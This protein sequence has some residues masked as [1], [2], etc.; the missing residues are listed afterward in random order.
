MLILT[1][2]VKLLDSSLT[3]YRCECAVFAVRTATLARFQWSGPT[4]VTG[5]NWSVEEA[6]CD[7]AVHIDRA[8]VRIVPTPTLCSTHTVDL[9]MMGDA[10]MLVH[11]KPQPVRSSMS[12]AANC[13]SSCPP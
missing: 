6:E 11:E 5:T 4:A 7:E 2:P 9:E 13:S 1:V 12:L 8:I 10:K 3:D